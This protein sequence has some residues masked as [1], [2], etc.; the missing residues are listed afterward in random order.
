M[1]LNWRWDEKCGEAIIEQTWK[2]ETKRFTKNLYEGNAFLIFLNEWEEDGVGK[3]S[4]YTFFADE[5]HAKRCLGINMNADKIYRNMF[6]DGYDKLVKLRVN[7]KKAHNWKKIITL[8]AQAFD[9]LEIE[10]YSEE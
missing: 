9:N 7:K 2:D 10:I 3:Y 6:E 8:F 5:A 4:L 1:S